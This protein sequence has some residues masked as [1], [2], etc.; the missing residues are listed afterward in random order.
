VERCTAIR[1]ARNISSAGRQPRGDLS[2]PFL[3]PHTTRDPVVPFRTEELFREKVA[4]AG[5]ADFLVQ[6]SVGEFG[7]CTYGKDRLLQVF[8]DLVLWVDQGVQPAS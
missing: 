1:Q 4:A 7:H 6:Q 5:K 8:A 2:N 3:T